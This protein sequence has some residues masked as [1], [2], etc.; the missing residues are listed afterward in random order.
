MLPMLRQLI[1]S[2]CTA[3]TALFAAPNA[4]AQAPSSDVSV[5]VFPF[6]VGNMN[7]RIA[8]IVNNCQT[9][10]IDTLYVSVF[11]ATGPQQ[12][13]LW[14]DD[15]AGTWSPSWGPVRSGGSGIDLPPLIAAC[16][17]ANVRVV[18]VLKCFDGSVQPDD[19]GHR[20][21]LLDVVDYLVDSWQ[22]NGAP[23]YDLDG[24]ALDYV[25]YVGSGAANAQNVTNFVADV[26]E[27]VGNLSLHAYLIANRYTFDGP[28]YNG[29]FNSYASVRSTLRGQFGQDWEQLAPL[30]DVL[31]PMSYS[32]DGSIYNTYAGHR[33][34]V[35][36]TAEYARQ[37]CTI[38]GVPTRRVVPA[39][40]TYSDSETATPQT[41]DASAVGALLGGA[42][43]YQAFRYQ[44]LVNTPSWWT[45]LASHA[46]P[47]CN[48]PRPILVSSAP[49]L[50]GSFDPTASTDVDQASGTLQAR[51]DFDGDGDFDTGWQPSAVTQALLRHPGQWPATMQVQDADGHVS[52]TRRRLTTGT[53]LTLFPNAISTI[54]GGVVNAFLDAGPAAAGHTYLTL[55]TLSGTAPGFQF[56]PGFPVPLNIDAVSNLFVGNPNGG[57]LQ[58]GL[59]TFDAAGR[60]T[61]VLSWP[62]QVLSFLAGFQM[63][64]SFVAVDPQGQPSC[65]GDSR[66]LQLQ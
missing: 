33:D 46:V 56:A 17:A 55:A 25:R 51:F 49:R 52:T 3:L 31:L 32:A 60:A 5:G 65:V 13:S 26:R 57:A 14:I 1:L 10:G 43:G 7:G 16:H 44:F 9:H 40:K 4:T 23:V 2:T 34:Y 37:A 54:G 24:L 35:R 39:I 53:P 36:K 19:A 59:G 62:P 47:G 50:T 64:W 21:F 27:R 63:H 66:M 22:P 20:A 11:R 45:P 30:L 6:L 42:D 12:G 8:E 29:V 48:W 61:T 38:A 18:G 15:R 28:T 58:G 41:I